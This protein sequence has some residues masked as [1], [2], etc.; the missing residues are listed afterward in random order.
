M[1]I[2]PAETCRFKDVYKLFER[3]QVSSCLVDFDTSF[4][5]LSFAKPWTQRTALL[6]QAR[7]LVQWWRR[8]QRV[9]LATPSLPQHVM[10]SS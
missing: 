3:Y 6:S 7:L 9:F 2:V 5:E 10:L 1:F 8:L 4:S